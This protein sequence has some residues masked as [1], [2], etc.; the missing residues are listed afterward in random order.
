MK[1]VSLINA[2]DSVNFEKD[3]GSAPPLGSLRVALA[4]K[5]A[6]AN[7]RFIDGQHYTSLD[8]VLG[9]IENDTEVAGITFNRVTLPTVRPLIKG[10]LDRGVK[11]IIAGGQAVIPI[12]EML[13]SD[14]ADSRI[15]ACLGDG[16]PT[17][18]GLVNG[19]RLPDVP[20][21]VYFDGNDVMKTKDNLIDYNN[22]GVLDYSKINGFDWKNYF[23]ISRKVF[24]NNQNP[25]SAYLADG[26]PNRIKEG[27][28]F[29]AR[30]KTGVVRSMSPGGAYNQL[31]H[32][33][34]VGASVVN[35]ESD[36][37]FSNTSFLRGLEEAMNSRGHLNLGLRVYGGVSELT[38]AN[39]DL[40][41]RLGVESILV[42]VESGNEEIRRMNGKYFSN[43]RLFDTLSACKEKGIKYNP[44]FVLGMIGETNETANETVDVARELLS[45]DG[46]SNVYASLFMPFPGSPAYNRINERL[47]QDP[48]LNSKHGNQFS[49]WDYDWSRLVDAQVEVS[50]N[51][52]R[53]YLCECL[54]SI[55]ILN[56][57]A[58]S[59]IGNYLKEVS[60]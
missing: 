15:M 24:D 26:C 54:D 52:S 7:V 2:P 25:A 51:T 12:G 13:V 50:T 56:K 39:L 53:D 3:A 58:R 17:I 30:R 47:A 19:D 55:N 22:L 38:E 11:R 43:Q 60:D 8:E 42:G 10:L 14:F 16:E 48:E 34:D 31:K 23:N 27:C 37:F 28:S 20:N 4:A 59:V 44:A 49:R 18:N 57:N 46:S 35:I 45:A 29:C 1:K 41:K 32:L 9:Q 33:Q 6:G 40:A 21:L 5:D 36:T